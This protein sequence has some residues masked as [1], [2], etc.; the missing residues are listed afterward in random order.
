MPSKHKRFKNAFKIHGK[1]M[2][3][4]SYTPMSKADRLAFAMAQSLFNGMF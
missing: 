4:N 2:Y 1:A 3:Y